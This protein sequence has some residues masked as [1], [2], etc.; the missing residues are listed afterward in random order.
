MSWRLKGKIKY[1]KSSKD[2]KKIQNKLVCIE[3]ADPGFDFIFSKKILGLITC[4][5]GPNSHMSIRCNELGV[6][7]VIGCGQSNFDEIIN[8]RI[9][10]INFDTKKIL[11]LS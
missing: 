5:G 10:E 4:Y 3:R 9:V 8:S 1:L 7:A 2:L 6:P 11:K